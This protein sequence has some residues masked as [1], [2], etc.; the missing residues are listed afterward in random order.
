MMSGVVNRHYV[1]MV[2]AHRLL[3]RT[4]A[5]LVPDLLASPTQ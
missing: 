4:D 5:F 1:W 2:V 3:A